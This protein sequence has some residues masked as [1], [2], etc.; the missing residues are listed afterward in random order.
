MMGAATQECQF[1]IRSNLGLGIF[2][3]DTPRC[4]LE[5]LG[6]EPL[7]DLL[8]SGQPGLPSEAGGFKSLKEKKIFTPRTNEANVF[9]TFERQ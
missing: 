6:N 1:A 7:I 3:K 8:I 2:P 9:H 5:K 4:G